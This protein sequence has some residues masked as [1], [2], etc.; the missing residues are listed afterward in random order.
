MMWKKIEYGV[1]N[2]RIEYRY[3]NNIHSTLYLI[4]TTVF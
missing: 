1:K 2:M 4:P 3:R